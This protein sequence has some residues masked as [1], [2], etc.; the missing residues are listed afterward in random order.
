V[1]N[2]SR[3]LAP[4]GWHIP[5]DEEWNILKAFLSES[6]LEG[7]KMKSISDWLENGNGTN[8]SGFTALPGGFCDKY[9][10][11]KNEGI[12]GEWWSSTN[13]YDE[14]WTGYYAFAISIILESANK[15]SENNNSDPESG[16]SVRCIKD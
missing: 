12:E 2:D 6:H 15:S 9:G 10:K 11:F 8:S 13:F 14:D 16:F 5:S 1:V 4:V 7:D 3:G